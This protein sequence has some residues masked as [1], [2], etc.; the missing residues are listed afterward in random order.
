MTLSAEIAAPHVQCFSGQ[1][2]SFIQCGSEWHRMT[3]RDEAHAHTGQDRQTGELNIGVFI[4]RRPGD[5]VIIGFDVFR[6]GL[7]LK[8]EVTERLDL[9]WQ[10]EVATLPS[11]TLRHLSRKAHFSLSFAE[12]PTTAARVEYWQGEIERA[13][14]DPGSYEQL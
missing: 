12:I 10:E 6:T 11:R 13:L 7:R 3:P 4:E 1:Q 5:R 14:S 2:H 8:R 9:K